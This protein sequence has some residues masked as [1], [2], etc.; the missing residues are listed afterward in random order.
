MRESWKVFVV[1]LV[2]LLV[3]QPTLALSAT[4]VRLIP[5]GNVSLLADGKE[6]RQLNSEMPLPQGTLMACNGNCL[7][8]TQSLQLVAQD[9]AVFGMAESAERW[10][11]T[12]KSGHVDFAL[13]GQAKPVAFHTPHDLIQTQQVIV[14]ANNGGLVRGYVAVAESGTEFRVLEGSVQVASSNGT[15][16][17]QAG[18]SI[19]LAQAQ[20]TGTAKQGKVAA[21]AGAAALATGGALAGTTGGISTASMVAAGVAAAGIATGVAVGTTGGS[22]NSIPSYVESPW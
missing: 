6:V 19:T 22:T 20:V 8:Q 7:V 12:I 2:A 1:V 5:S 16:M 11:L 18:N 17:V 3:A 15:Q 14:P 4:P 21:G 9:K 10:D 13:T